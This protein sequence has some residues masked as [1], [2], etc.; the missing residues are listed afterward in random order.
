M[1]QNGETADG[2]VTV[3][4]SRSPSCIRS[5][6]IDLSLRT[7]AHILYSKTDLSAIWEKQALVVVSNFLKSYM[8]QNG[9]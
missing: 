5:S 8:A 7:C 6:Y 1:S 9:E 2:N 3:E 4:V